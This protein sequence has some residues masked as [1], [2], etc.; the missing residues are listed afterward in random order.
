MVKKID[1]FVK[2]HMIALILLTLVIGFISGQFYSKATIS[3]LK[4]LILPVAFSMLWA[5]MIE[6]KIQKFVESFKYPKQLILGNTLSLVIAPLIMLPIAL[7]FAKSPKMFAGLVLAG[8][9]P[10][11]GF[12]TYWTMI[13][14]ANM[15]LA[16]SLTLTT[17]V[18][19]LGLIPFGMKFLAGGKVAVDMGL[20]FNKILI[21]VVGP[22]LLAMLTRY[23]ITRKQGEKR[24]ADFKPYFH[25]FSSI[26]AFCIV[27]IGVSVKSHFILAHL[28]MIL[29][30]AVGALIY[31]IIA[32]PISYVIA[33]NIFKSSLD[34][35]IP[36]VFGT[37]TKNLSI[38][39]G[40]AAAAF[41][42]LT[43]LAVVTCMI[44]QM[45]FASIWHKVFLKIQAGETALKAMEEE[46][47]EIE[48]EVA[49]DVLGKR[50]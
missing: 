28:S 48:E 24:L 11:G 4:S 50:E 1:A 37:A 32:Y 5:S 19:S 13:L 15:G 42:P 31:Y 6:L 49:E 16:V 20:L 12:I 29:L 44:F 23:L 2:K 35:T 14:G 47:V 9:V 26:M 3:G 46:A 43:L 38:A 8:L 36:I 41:G 33:R 7:I 21:L 45:P 27:F 10:P 40:L 18:V 39:M 17:F 34:D 30:P 22:F 25:L